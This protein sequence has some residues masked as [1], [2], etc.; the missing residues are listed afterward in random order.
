LQRFLFSRTNHAASRK[1]VLDVLTKET[2]GNVA[3]LNEF[4]L[5]FLKRQ[6]NP[7]VRPRSPATPSPPIRSSMATR[8][9]GT[10]DDSGVRLFLSGNLTAIKVRDYKPP[11]G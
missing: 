2:G 3:L 8:R 4:K 1:A 10:K 6:A 7:P 9:L 11:L 5:L